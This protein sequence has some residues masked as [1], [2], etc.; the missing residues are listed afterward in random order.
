MLPDAG[1][2][3]ASGFVMLIETAGDCRLSGKR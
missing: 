3:V 2:A 1:S